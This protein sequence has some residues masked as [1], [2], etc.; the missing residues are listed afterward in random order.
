MTL[1]HL[2]HQ[3]HQYTRREAIADTIGKVTYSILVGVGL[4]Y[5]QAGLRGWGI[6]SARASATAVNMVTGSP[7]ARWRE[8]WYTLTRTSE[9]SSKLRKSVVELGAFNTFETYVYGL[10]AGIGSLISTGTLDLEK[11]TDGM[12][13]LLYLSPLIGPTMGMWL[14]GTCK[15][16]G[17]KTVAERAH[18]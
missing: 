17:I 7:Y 16:F 10:S 15:M 9:K 6:V 8:G 14:N 2:L 3:E 1:D 12:A 5:F 11:I 18:R 13:G 4:D